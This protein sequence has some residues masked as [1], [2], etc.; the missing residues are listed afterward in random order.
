MLVSLVCFIYRTLEAIMDHADRRYLPVNTA[1]RFARPAES[2]QAP[3]TAASASA[4]P[5]TIEPTDA[6][7]YKAAQAVYAAQPQLRLHTRGRPLSWPSKNGVA[8][9]ITTTAAE[10]NSTKNG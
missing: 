6:S 4:E 8:A 9:L 10:R 5:L 3:R 7:I 2:A 1:A